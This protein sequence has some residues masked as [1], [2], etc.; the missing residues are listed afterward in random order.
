MLLASLSGW[1]IAILVVVIVLLF[2]A[3]NIPK[4][5]RSIGRAKGEF[6]KGL[7]DGA[8]EAA[9]APAKPADAA[10]G[11]NGKVAATPAPDAKK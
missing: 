5:A 6:E 10:P 8:E 1:H 3:G 4:L 2:G 11:T 9:A 7:K